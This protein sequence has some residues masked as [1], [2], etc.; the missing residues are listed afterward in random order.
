MSSKITFHD[1]KIDIPIR[2]GFLARYYDDIMYIIY[3]GV[4]CYLHCSDK[5]YRIEASLKYL[6]DYLPKEIFFECNR[7]TI[8]NIHYIKEYNRLDAF[9]LMDDNRYF[10]LSRR[11]VKAFH[12]IRMLATKPLP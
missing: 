5:E 2:T 7:S 10:G 3:D 6:M 11:R 1:R 8:I 12:Q 9:I 4:Y